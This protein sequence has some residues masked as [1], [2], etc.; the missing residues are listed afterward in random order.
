VRRIHG[1]PALWGALAVLLAYQYTPVLTIRAGDLLAAWTYQ[2][3]Y[4]AEGDTRWSGARAEVV[5][6]DPGTGSWHVEVSA[7]GWRPRRMEPPILR[8]D[9]GGQGVASRLS[10]E[11]ATLAL[12]STLTGLWDSSARL[13][14][15]TDTFA[16]G[17]QDPRA[18]GANV[19]LVRVVPESS[20]GPRVPPLREV[21][22]GALASMLLA[23]LLGHFGVGRSARLLIAAVSIGL[24]FVAARPWAVLLAVP[25][26]AV[27]L[28]GSAMLLLAPTRSR[29]FVAFLGR[30]AKVPLTGA[31]ALAG[32]KAVAL[33]A[34]TAVCVWTAY[35]SQGEIDIDVGSQR[36]EAVA[37]GFGAFEGLNGVTFR[38]PG[39]GAVLDLRDFGRGDAWEVR[40]VASRASGEGPYEVRWDGGSARL[41]ASEEW[42][43]SS[44]SAVPLGSWRAGLAIGF[45]HV[46]GL[47]IDRVHVSRGHSTPPLR[48]LVLCL[49]AAALAG[50]IATG[51][52]LS[53]AMGHGVLGLFGVVEAFFLFRTPLLAIPFVPVLVTILVLTLIW[54]SILSTARPDGLP[55]AAVAAACAGFSAWVASTA[56][57]L[58]RGG[59]FVFHSSIAE[60]IWKGRFLIYYLPF[61]GSMLSRQAQWGDIVVPHPCL[62]HTLVSPLAALPHPLFYF[63]EKVVLAALLSTLPLFAG[64]LAARASGPA[65]GAYGAAAAACLVP[66]FQ[67][68]GLGHLMTIL[69]IVVMAGT[70]TILVTR[71][72]SLGR[73]SSLAIVTAALTLSFLSYTAALLFSGCVVVW[74]LPFLWWAFP[75]AS[76]SLLKALLLAC[77]FA[78]LLYYGNWAWPFLKESIPR[79]VHGRAGQAPHHVA[80]GARL[81]LL[82][83]KL[84]YSYGTLLIP[85]VGL[86][87]LSLLPRE[88]PDRVFLLGWGFVLVLFSA[89]DLYFNLLLKHH[90]FTQTPIAV[91]LGIVLE[92]VARRKEGGALLAA[93]GLL[94]CAAFGL[95]TARDVALGLIP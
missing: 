26:V 4:G 38:E 48:T 20:L 21:C 51:V 39:P 73:A 56:S 57:P 17:A 64:W 94:V 75:R 37:R 27:L 87:G 63:S 81:A 54:G 82:P 78:L 34:L 30:A 61:P 5:L 1:G 14:L 44:F 22:L 92:R 74:S 89:V 91:G 49:I 31:Q 95:W 86:A 80:L 77:L 84:D 29:T 93:A 7:S 68:L 60:E 53:P 10:R 19:S 55:V 3:F 62:Y 32:W 40:I 59:H 79:I 69:G 71:F 12:D 36:E 2:G 43:E 11:A 83:G 33:L 65:A 24:A 76:R 90:Y 52:G 15:E 45:P 50:I 18:L 58:Y 67:L 88:R 8:V 42:R 41:V 35:R 28:A 66:T 13:K 23:W 16:P 9:L 25:T 70:M 47:R 85:L 72:E 6:P 46:P